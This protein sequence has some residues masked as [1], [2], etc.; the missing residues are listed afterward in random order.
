MNGEQEEQLYYESMHQ[1]SYKIQDNMQ[2]PMVYLA[3]YDLDTMY[4]D[5]K[6]K[7]PYRKEFLNAAIIEVIN[8][9]QTNK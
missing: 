6:M 3:N 7:H 1:D 4:F 9:C 8:H 2:D 5:Q